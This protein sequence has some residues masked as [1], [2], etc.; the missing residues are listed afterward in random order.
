[1]LNS[2]I[3]TITRSGKVY[4]SLSFFSMISVLT[5]TIPLASAYGEIS[6]MNVYVSN[7]PEERTRYIFG[8]IISYD[9][10]CNS[11][12]SRCWSSSLMRRSYS[13]SICVSTLHS[14]QMCLPSGVKRE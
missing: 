5:L 6:I 4:N 7:D 13:K 2:I 1:M 11:G 9:S 14:G 12:R 10:D 3:E 8:A